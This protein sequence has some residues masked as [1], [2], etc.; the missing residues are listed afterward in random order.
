[1]VVVVVLLLLLRALQQLLVGV[2][3]AVQ[4]GVVAMALVGSAVATSV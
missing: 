1:V 2:E 3:A 4:Q